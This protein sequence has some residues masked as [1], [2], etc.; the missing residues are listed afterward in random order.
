MAIIPLV[1][2]AAA[3]FFVGVTLFIVNRRSKKNKNP[4]N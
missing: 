1:L 3:I 2:L 4:T